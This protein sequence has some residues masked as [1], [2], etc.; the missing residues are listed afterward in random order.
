LKKPMGDSGYAGF[1]GKP[2]EEEVTK[3]AYRV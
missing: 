2:G 3:T 1:K